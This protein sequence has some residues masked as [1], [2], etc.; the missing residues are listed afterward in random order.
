MGALLELRG[1]LR[2]LQW[3]GEVNRRGF[4]KI[5]KKLDKKV[6]EV[7]VQRRY[8]DS[9]VDVKPFATNESLQKLIKTI[10]EWLSNLGEMKQF[11]D[12]T[13]VHSVHSIGRV[14]AKAILNLPQGLLDTV[15]QA[16]RTDDAAI[17]MELLQEANVE[18]KDPEGAYQR[19]LLNLLQKAISC[20]SKACIAKLLGK[21]D[22][23]E[24]GDDINQRNCLHRLLISLGRTKSAEAAMKLA[25]LT[26][27]DPVDSS[28]FITP[29]APPLLASSSR[30]I[31][32][33]DGSK[34]FGRN[35]PSILI[36]EHV[37]D[38]LRPQQRS[39]LQARDVY[40]R[41]PLHYAAQYGFVIIC[42]IIIHRMQAWDQF[43]VSEGIDA[44]YWQDAEGLAPLHLSVMGGHPLTTQTLLG[45]ESWTGQHDR[46]S[47]M[48]KHSSKSSEV[49]ALAT[50]ENFEVIV[51]LLVEAG[52]DL[53]HQ[54]EQGETALHVAA[55]FGYSK[56]AEVLLRGTTTQKADTEIAE[57]TFGWTPL[58]VA[59][60]D[61][62]LNVVKLLIEAGAD[63]ERYD[64]SGWTAKEH[65]SL[66][67]HLQIAKLLAQ[68]TSSPVLTS[69]NSSVTS[70]SPPSSFSLADRK[71]N[72]YSNS[73][74]SGKTTEPIKTF[75]HRYL[76]D[77]S[78][79]LVSLGTMDMRKSIPAVKLERIPL[80]D[81]HSTQL[82]TALS[83]I[84]SASGAHGEPSII[85]LPVQE[86][87]STE[88]IVF[89]T[90]DANKVKIMFD[91][92]PTYAGSRD[93][94]VGRGVALLSSIKPSIG[95]K[96]M[97]LQGD[98]TVPIMAAH[99]LEVI[100]CVHFN[101]QIITPFKHPNMS[102]TEKATYWKSMTSTMVIGHRGNGSSDV[103]PLPFAL[104]NILAKVWVKTWLRESLYS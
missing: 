68:K 33:I 15:D 72:G 1:S 95:S 9:K 96:K 47:V 90:F 81:A 85:D 50:K 21:I 26:S 76:T 102:I 23:L 100:G 87:I 34:D 40:G 61:G 42:Q 10:N 30:I 20:R 77:E 31:K 41:M 43:D 63:L 28:N 66:R 14:S 44:S 45:A 104:P 53:N 78:M 12:T 38:H 56:C 32:E 29:A 24:E 97:S 25:V 88:P 54:D 5:T 91:I 62:H 83:V 16:I 67:G 3:Y 46:K 60:V 35:D 13:S 64:S 48:R 101:F 94:I 69:S 74:G 2:K 6:P 89:T 11:D 65:A 58:H 71:S 27:Q 36:L 73:N 99:N 80:T 70:S 82:D 8:L 7:T 37:L 39:A 93:Q 57:K 19:L 84:V 79:V 98:V 86:N 17:L 4:I 52:V 55:R 103:V 18:R 59:S 75:G 22:T 92:V 51:Q 49:L